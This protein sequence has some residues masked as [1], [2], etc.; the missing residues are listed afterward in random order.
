MLYHA[1]T[2]TAR[3]HERVDR[4][5]ALH[6]SLS[7]A[8]TNAPTRWQTLFRR[9]ALAR[10]VRGSIAIEGLE[11][12]VE[13]AI[14]IGEGE[15]AID[16]SPRAVAAAEGFTMAKSYVLELATDPHFEYS[17][18]LIRSLHYMMMR[19]DAS[20]NPGRWR[21]GPTNLLDPSQKETV[22]DGPDA[23]EI[24]ELARE[25]FHHLNENERSSTPAV[26][27]G[28]VAYMN[29]LLLQPFSDGNG[30]MAR[31]LQSLVTA[32]AEPRAPEYGSLSE[33]LG[34]NT[35]AYRAAMKQVSGRRWEPS[36][37]IRSW[38]DF[39]L[40]AHEQHLQTL[41]NRARDMERLWDLLEA[42]VHRHELPERVICALLDAAGGSRVRNAMYRSAA[43]ISDQVAGR[44]LV[45]AVGAGLLVSQ[46]DG[47]GRYYK[48]S[49]EL[50][51][52]RDRTHA[53]ERARNGA[54]AAA[55]G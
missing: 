1:P 38:L 29:L 19:H 15:S 40:T 34:A 3:D 32:R 39:C 23:G 11:L 55:V 21:S 46:G 54:V 7:Y 13:D 50:R 14:A 18:A 53:P 35:A 41:L 51:A 52:I 47:R 20:A 22:Y 5:R 45:Q 44:D 48:R 30:R 27:R 12:S 26:V 24:P 36:R 31:C 28:A 43:E 17:D 8:V 49:E 37:D 42:E 2:L 10:A 25:L 6:E 9:D 4:I 16:A 33:Y